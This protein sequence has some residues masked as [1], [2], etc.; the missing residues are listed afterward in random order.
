M[1]L[2]S[3]LSVTL[4]NV[5]NNSF[6]LPYEVPQ[7]GRGAAGRPTLDMARPGST[8]SAAEGPCRGRR[9][10]PGWVPG[11]A[12]DD[13]GAQGSHRRNR[14]LAALSRHRAHLEPPSLASGHT[15]SNTPGLIRTRKLSGERPG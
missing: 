11:G 6:P 9:R 15:S 1:R 12:G 13:E 3:Q 4:A 5:K 10:C 14:P 7:I 8:R 2:Q